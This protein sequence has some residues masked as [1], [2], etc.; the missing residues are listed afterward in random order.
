[1]SGLNS[2]RVSCRAMRVVVSSLMLEMPR[3]LYKVATTISDCG[4]CRDTYGDVCQWVELGHLFT[5][6]FEFTQLHK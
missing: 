5:L 4:Q 1:M 3:R 6:L 2:P